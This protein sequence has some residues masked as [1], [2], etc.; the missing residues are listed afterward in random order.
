MA[1]ETATASEPHR[2]ATIEDVAAAAGVSVA[3]VSRAI[4]GLPNV[5]IST[6]ERVARAADALSYRADPAA[7]RLA[8][9]RTTSVGVVVPYLNGWYFSQVVAGAEAVLAAEGYDLIVMGIATADDRRALFDHGTS[10]HRRVDGLVLVDVPL[11]SRDTEILAERRLAVVSVG[12]ESDR[13]PSIGIDDEAVGEIATRHLLE[14][15]HTRIGLIGGQRA[16]PFGFLVPDLRRRGYERA[17][18]AAGIDV[19][20]RLETVGHFSIPGGRD[21]ARGLLADDDPPTAMFAMSDEMAFGA[22]LAA[23]DLG[24]DVPGDMSVVGVDD[25]D[26]SE[27]VRLTT[28]RQPVADHGARAARMVIDQLTGVERRA[29]RTERPVELVVRATTAAHG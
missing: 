26:V 24:L 4:R 27:V 5:A 15:G 25:H 20:P 13:F 19:D 16:E 10:I 14:L 21:A 18:S 22:I 6:R 8:T 2:R 1:T 11:S 12:D 23:R 7:A 3:T 9:G 28:V 17:L 29:H